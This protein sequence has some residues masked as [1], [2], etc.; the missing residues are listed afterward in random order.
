MALL[1][2]PELLLRREVKLPARGHA[3]GRGV[4][5]DTKWVL[6]VHRAPLTNPLKGLSKQK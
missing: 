6:P 2:I 1:C 4:S 3:A 5:L